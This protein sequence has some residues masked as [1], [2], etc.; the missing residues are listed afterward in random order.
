MGAGRVKPSLII[1][2]LR[3]QI[4]SFSNRVGGAAEFAAAVADESYALA[5]PHAFVIPN[6]ESATRNETVPIVTQMIEE[7]MSVLVAV[8]NT[9]A[10]RGQDAAEQMEGTIKP[11]LWAALLGWSPD[12]TVYGL[13]EYAEGRQFK[14]D[15]ARL[16]WQFDFVTQRFIQ[17]N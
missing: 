16:W 13:F 10:A 17:S 12:A 8:D 4:A 3:S 5:V 6:A 15:R 1:P 14:I 11:A 2:R 7:T 9:I